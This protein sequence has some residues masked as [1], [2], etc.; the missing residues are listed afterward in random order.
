MLI[1]PLRK[2]E[3]KI[4]DDMSEAVSP[5]RVPTARTIATGPEA[6]KMN[7][8]I[9]LTRYTP[10]KSASTCRGAGG[11]AVGFSSG[12]DSLGAEPRD[13]PREGSPAQPTL[14]ARRTRVSIA[15]LV[16][17]HAAE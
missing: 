9:A 5:P 14:P 15:R 16:H 11:D 3:P 13:S 6:A 8:T 12:I 7:A 17:R 1:S 2:T 10:P 4:H